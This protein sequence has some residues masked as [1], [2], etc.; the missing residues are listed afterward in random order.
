MHIR[1]A[2]GAFSADNQELLDTCLDNMECS[3]DS[4]RQQ[5]LN[6]LGENS[7]APA[8]KPVIETPYNDAG[9]KNFIANVAQALT[10][11]AGLSAEKDAGPM[12][13]YSLTEIARM[14][15]ERHGVRTANM[16]KMNLIANA[17]THSSGDFGAVLANTANKAMLKGWEETEETFQAFCSDG[18][19]SDF[20]VVDRV[21]LGTFPSLRQVRPGAEYKSVTV[22]DRSEQVQLATYGELF[23]INRQAIINDDLNVFTQIPRKMGRAAIRTI[24]DLVFAILNSNPNMKDGVALF[25]ATHNNLLGASGINTAGL[26]AARVKMAKQKDGDATLNLMPKHILV[27][28]DLQTAATVALQSEFEVGASTKNNTTPNGVRN[29]VDSIISDARLAAG[30]WFLL[31]D[32]NMHDT[33]EVQWLDGIKQ[34]SLEQQNGWNIDGV[35]FKVRIDAGVKALDSK[36]MNK[37]PTT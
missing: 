4:A 10:F 32:Q 19:L 21:D 9:D 6:A 18:E 20:K 29:M 25:H 13:G 36:T 24:G 14:S 7:P 35:E 2:F 26:D 11:R 28:T 1:T 23:S 16:D 30:A 34:P 37:T 17:F 5:L 27:P 8:K 22:G 33:I 31:A 3:V 15:L 12:R